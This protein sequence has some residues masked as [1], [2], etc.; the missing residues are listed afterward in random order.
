[1]TEIIVKTSDATEEREIVIVM[2]SVLQTS[3][4]VPCSWI[5]NMKL[6]SDAGLTTV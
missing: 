6:S 3:G 2:K 1:M 5:L 4:S